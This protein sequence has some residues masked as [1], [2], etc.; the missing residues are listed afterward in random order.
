MRPHTIKWLV[1]IVVLGLIVIGGYLLFRS[2]TSTPPI[3]PPVEKAYTEHKVIGKS[4]EGRAI[5]AYTYG[6]GTTSILFVG[7]THGGY[8]WNSVLLAYEYMDY[9]KAHP[10]SLASNLSVTVIPSANPDGLYEVVGKEGRFI[11]SDVSVSTD[12]QISGRLNANG[13]D[14]N[15]NF[16]CNWEAD[17][18]WRKASVSGGSAPFSEPEALAI[19][20]YVLES[21]PVA[22][23]F[24]H[25]QA[26]AVYASKCN[27]DTL[28][29]T[30][31][32]MNA[33]AKASGYNA[34]PNFDAYKVTGDSEGWL[35]S[36]GIPAITVELTNH[37]DIEWNKNLSG[38]RAILEDYAGK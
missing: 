13:V 23:I 7:G 11:A 37:S 4:V 29:E 10:D 38:V 21:K 25:S 6:T 22:V 2:P 8:E 17:G 24:W 26:G 20:N 28:P 15:R 32:I 35:A 14:L 16:D 19:K 3:A 36:I 34:V 27:E 18:I 9:L 12:V 30:L 31:D 33:Y 5:D 1:G